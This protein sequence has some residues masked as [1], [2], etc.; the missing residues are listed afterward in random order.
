MRELGV[1]CLGD[2]ARR[3]DRSDSSTSVHRKAQEKQAVKMRARAGRLDGGNELD[4]GAIVRLKLDDV[5]RA[6]LDNS[7]AVCVVLAKEKKSYRVANRAGMYKELIS[8]P[9]LQLVPHA[10]PEMMGLATIL[11]DYSCSAALP[12]VS[13][14]GIARADSHAGGQ[15]FLRCNCKGDCMSPRCKCYRLGLVCNSRCHPKNSRCCNHDGT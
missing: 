7:T 11:H 4:P 1:S 13:I 3:F 9:H 6:K 5:D 12:Q 10:T 14:R 15:G 2:G 8:R